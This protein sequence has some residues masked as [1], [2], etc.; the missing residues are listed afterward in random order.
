MKGKVF[1]FL[2]IIL[3]IMGCLECT[4][5][6]LITRTLPIVDSGAMAFG[7]VNNDGALDFL[8]AGNDGSP[9]AT[10]P[11]T[12]I[13]L[14]TNFTNLGATNVSSGLPAVAGGAVAFG[15]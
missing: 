5:F 6:N 10:F 8:L 3:M 13:S 7:D 11:S 4:T 9:T 14:I 12:A 2:S 15:D 1:I